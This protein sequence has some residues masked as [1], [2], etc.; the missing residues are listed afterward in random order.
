MYVRQ[1]SRT[2]AAAAI[3]CGMLCSASSALGWNAVGHMIVAQLAYSHLS[4]ADR[5]RLTTILERHPHFEQYLGASLP[6][7]R[8]RGEWATMRSAVWPDWIRPPR[9][10]AGPIGEH[11]V[12]RFHRGTWHYINF[13]YL[14]GQQSAALPESGLQADTDILRQLANCVQYGTATN[15]DDATASTDPDAEPT[16]TAEQNRAVRLAWLTHLVGDLHQPLHAVSSVDERR[17]PGPRH[18][19]Q[20][21]N[22]LAVRVEIGAFPIRLHSFWDQL[23]GTDNHPDSIGRLVDD[24]RN[25]PALQRKLLTEL[26]DGDD[27]RAWAGESYAIAKQTA[28]LDGDLPTAVYDESRP[29]LP[30]V[31]DVPI[32]PVGYERAAREA[33]RRRLVLAGYR[34]AALLSQAVQ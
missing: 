24:L 32:L 27:F 26:N 15:A 25:D 1:R 8:E 17:L 10:L 5:V 28:Y 4:E 11:P 30:A 34:L 18:D 21:G 14:A 6:E 23:P 7:G 31:D 33:A 9:R 19:D 12:H 29:P 16:T 2:L 22:L 3:F 20:G 13:P